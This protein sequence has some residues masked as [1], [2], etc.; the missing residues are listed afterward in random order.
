M[1]NKII[2]LMV[3]IFLVFIGILVVLFMGWGIYYIV[4]GG[5][6]NVLF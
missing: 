6:G 5:L 4:I 1:S 2:S 3:F